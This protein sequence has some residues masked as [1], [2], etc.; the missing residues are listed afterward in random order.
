[1]RALIVTEEGLRYE[2]AA[3]PPPC[4]PGEALIRVH[5]A[6]I[7]RTDLEIV[8]GYMGFRG[9][10][11]HEFVGQ[12]EACSEPAWVGKRVTAEINAACGTC[13][14]CRAGLGRH[15][16]ARTTLGILGRN[17][18]LAEW[19]AM[20]VRCLHE[21]PA[22]LSDEEA[23]FIEPLAAA[24]EILEQVAVPEAAACTVLGDGKLGILCAWTLSR[25]A[26]Q[27]LLV[28]HHPAKLARAAWEGLRTATEPPPH[29]SQDLVVEATGTGEGL[30][31]AI[32]VT[33][34]R[35]TLI[36]K[37]T[38]VSPGELNLA[39]AVVKELTIVGSRCGPFDRAIKAL[40]AYRFP[41][42]RLIDGD[43]PLERGVE[44]FAHAARRD[45]LKIL[46]RPY[47]PPQPVPLA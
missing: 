35:G 20:P 9:V 1:M 37:S 38:V 30:M 27:V 2:P 4:P 43:Y 15:C 13:D 10:P 19:C 29:D 34:P 17:G 46:V 36:L 44:A 3:A 32:N 39:R 23:V 7:C 24:H 6:G 16:A 21:V 14:R 25:V 5:R 33:R 41:V 42:A 45:A 11:G 28:G 47:P 18:A 12:V 31:Q 8:R 40:R 26:R 22:D